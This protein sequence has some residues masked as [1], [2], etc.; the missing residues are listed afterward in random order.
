[1]ITGHRSC[2][3]YEGLI[4]SCSVSSLGS[5]LDV[6]LGSCLIASLY[7]LGNMA[8]QI[9]DDRSLLAEINLS[10]AEAALLCEALRS[11]WLSP[12][13]IERTWQEMRDIIEAERLDKKWDT[14]VDALLTRLGGL[15]RAQATAL[16]RATIRF[17]ERHEEPT[18]T[19]L[20]ELGLIS[21]QLRKRGKATATKRKRT[22]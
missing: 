21:R 20:K 9:P 5:V 17:W 19:L 6:P 22:R 7:R 14:S 12:K 2:L 16:L 13:F 4:S 15:R 18:A 1:M 3:F 8:E 10:F 11:L